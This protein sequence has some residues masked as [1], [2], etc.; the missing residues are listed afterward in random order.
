MALDDFLDDSCCIYLIVMVDTD[1]RL[2]SR[3]SDN[4]ELVYL[5]ELVFLGHSGTGHTGEL[6][7]EA[8]EVLESDSCESL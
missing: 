8:E 4:V 1:N 2:V 6:V 7:I 5:L 3:Y